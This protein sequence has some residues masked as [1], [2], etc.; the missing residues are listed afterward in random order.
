MKQFRH[1]IEVTCGGS[2]CE[3][4]F[5]LYYYKDDPHIRRPKMYDPPAPVAAK[6]EVAPVVVVPSGEGKAKNV[7][8][9]GKPVNTEGA[10]WTLE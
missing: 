6:V 9:A 1:R 4:E 3:M 10:N 8:V 5:S 7:N 2:E